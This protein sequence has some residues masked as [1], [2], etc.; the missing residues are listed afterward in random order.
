MS[1][2]KDVAQ[3]EGSLESYK[4]AVAPVN[5]A[6][7]SLDRDL[8]FVGTTDLGDIAIVPAD[9]IDAHVEGWIAGEPRRRHDAGPERELRPVAAAPGSDVRRDRDDV[10]QR[11][12]EHVH[13][14]P[15]VALPEE[16]ALLRHGC[17]RGGVAFRG[18]GF[19]WLAETGKRHVFH[20]VGGRFTLEE[21]R[22]PIEVSFEQISARRSKTRNGS[23]VPSSYEMLQGSHFLLH[24]QMLGIGLPLAPFEDIRP[25]LEIVR[26]LGASTS[27]S[28]G[29][30]GS[31]VT[32]NGLPVLPVSSMARTWA[33]MAVPSRRSTIRPSST[34]SC[35]STSR[36]NMTCAR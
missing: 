2:E 31:M 13:P 35:R 4:S 21:D 16:V 19:L 7:L 22:R 36:S 3:L 11:A 30:P 27:R 29:P 33:S 6:T 23:I 32:W 20:L 8:V 18:K 12:R 14:R 34:A 15:A 24:A 10:V 17:R 1:E 5:K 9:A 28:F 25:L 26:P